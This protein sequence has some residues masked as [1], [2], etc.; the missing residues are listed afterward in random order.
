MPLTGWG[1][2]CCTESYH[3]LGEAFCCLSAQIFMA[4]ILTA[5]YLIGSS[6]WGKPSDISTG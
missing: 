1:D 6:Y 5:H 4:A 2:A 3:L